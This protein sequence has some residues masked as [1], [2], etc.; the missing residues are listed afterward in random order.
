[1][2]NPSLSIKLIIYFFPFTKKHFFLILLNKADI[3]E[4]YLNIMY[5]I[6]ISHNVSHAIL[7]K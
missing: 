1:M 2:S 4:L 6:S 3:F 5:I 7:M